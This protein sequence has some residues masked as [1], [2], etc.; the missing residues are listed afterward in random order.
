MFK[1]R[2]R[3]APSPTGTPHIGNI[4]T[5]LFNFLFAKNQ[6]GDFI[7]RIEDTDRKRLVPESIDAIKES[8]KSLNLSWDGKVYLQSERLEIYSGALKE[9]KGKKLVYQNDGAW[10][11]KVPKGKFLKWRDKVHGQVQFKS[12]VVEDFVIIKS[13]NYPTYHFASVIDDH[14]MEI[15]HVI[16]GDEWI[17]STPKHLLLYEAFGWQPPQ[18]VHV[19]P[20]VAA[21]KKKLS[22]RDGAKSVL[23]YIREG[24]LPEA[25]V[26]FLALLGWTPKNDQEIF[27]LEELITEFSLDRLNKNSP[28]FNI[29]KLKW[30]NGQWIRR[31]KEEEF[32]KK[33]ND[34][35]PNYSPNTT[36][37]VAQLTQDRIG[38]LSDYSKLADF[39]YQK[40]KE[41]PPV[42]SSSETIIN[43]I[44][45]FKIAKEWRSSIL[46]ELIDK[47][48][49]ASGENRI[50][51][52]S[53]IR[54][55]VSGSTVT[56][57]LYESLEKLGQNETVDRLENYVKDKTKK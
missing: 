6:N 35:Y 31:L 9:L 7:L 17:S 23:E 32:I 30:F 56:P 55:I 36:Q 54:N 18:F 20:I 49:Q 25:I 21:N 40:P 41:W 45:V 22:K 28:I 42:K 15:S 48:A 5:A 24:Y 11:F 14:E 33:I 1:V 13:D 43:I 47:T 44:N 57:P 16:R 3:Y 50:D 52:I 37:N 34:Y 10:F 39:F 46:K 8:L 29:E 26:N 4:R 12:E 19:P 38:T 2:T 27:S 51:L 53:S